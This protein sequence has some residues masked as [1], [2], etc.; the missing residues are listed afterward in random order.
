MAMI[1][2]SR[3]NCEAQVGRVTPWAPLV[4]KPGA[5]RTE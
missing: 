4:V 2:K 3:R 1:N 5:A